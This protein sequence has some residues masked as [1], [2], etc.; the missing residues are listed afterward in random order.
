MN[1]FKCKNYYIIKIRYYASKYLLDKYYN[2]P[3][4]NEK[5]LPK[6]HH[7]RAK[8]YTY[9]FWKFFNHVTGIEDKDWYLKYSFESRECAK[10]ELQD[11][12]GILQSDAESEMIFLIPKDKE[13]IFK[14][15]KENVNLPYKI[16][17]VLKYIPLSFLYSDNYGLHPTRRKESEEWSKI[18]LPFNKKEN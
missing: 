1:K 16:V 11:K 6:Q 5:P 8:I 2:D 17:S 10:D 7:E 12:F 18:H 4:H 14:W 9:F 13:E 3:N 15:V